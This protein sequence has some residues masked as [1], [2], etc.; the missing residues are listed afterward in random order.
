MPVRRSSAGFTLVE[1]I[2]VIVILGVL[3]LG[4]VSFIS[5]SSRGFAA[6]V[7]RTELG[8]EARFLVQRLS[9][10]LRRALPGSLRASGSCLEYIPIVGASRYVT[11]PVATPSSTFRSV[12]VDPLPVPAGVRVAVYPDASAYALASPGP[13]SP[14][15]TVS[16][17]DASNEVTVTMA[18]PHRFASESPGQRYFLVG[19][20]ISYCVD[21]GSLFRYVD[22]GFVA[23]QPDPTT[24]PGTLPER[25][26]LAQGVLGGAPF[27]VNGATHSRNAVVGVDM[28]LA[29]DADQVSINHLVQVRNAP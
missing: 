16:G 4:T 22:Y 27:T 1:L 15:V 5:D 7:A 28:V 11:L 18:A 23:S 6:T 13:L 9:R 21:G 29:R 14:P 25:A 26:P 8:S 19:E 3:G 12:P 2:T 17:P 24:L 10:E 20:P